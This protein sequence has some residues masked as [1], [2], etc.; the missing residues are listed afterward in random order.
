MYETQYCD[1]TARSLGLCLLTFLQLPSAISTFFWWS[2]LVGLT[3][4][5]RVAT[6]WT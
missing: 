4:A 3:F 2:F 6:T 1:S 5:D